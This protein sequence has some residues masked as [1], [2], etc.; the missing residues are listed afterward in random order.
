MPPPSTR[1]SA[2][3]MLLDE[4]SRLLERLKPKRGRKKAGDAEGPDGDAEV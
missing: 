1:L 3:L 2:P 4:L